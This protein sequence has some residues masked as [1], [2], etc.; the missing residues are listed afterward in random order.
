MHVEKGV[1]EG[2]LAGLHL[3]D[4]RDAGGPGVEPFADLAE[5]GAG[6]AVH[7]AVERVEGLAQE[8][9]LLPLPGG[10]LHGA[11]PLHVRR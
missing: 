4:D 11:I 5:V 9:Q 7:R 10:D 3:P 6:L 2:G 1:E 8:I